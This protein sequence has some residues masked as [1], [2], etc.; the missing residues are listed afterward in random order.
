MEVGRPERPL[1]A[2]ATE[3]SS[4]PYD[5][6]VSGGPSLNFA[7]RSQTG[8]ARECRAEPQAKEGR[9]MKVDTVFTL[10]STCQKPGMR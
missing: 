9:A 10:V 5:R 3:P 6:G 4:G 1:T 2:V 8:V 7:D